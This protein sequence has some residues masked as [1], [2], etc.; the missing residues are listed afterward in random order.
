MPFLKK[1]LRKFVLIFMN[2]ILIFSKTLEEHMEHLRVVFQTL[3]EH[4]L[5]IKFSK[6]TF[7]YQQIIYLGHIIAQ[8]GVAT[9]STK[10]TPM[11]HWHVP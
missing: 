8:H 1:Y 6:C 3:M 9:D 10:T 7:A 5:Y 11:V 4:N 2:D